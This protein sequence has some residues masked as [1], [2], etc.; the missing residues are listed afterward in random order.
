M[1][2]DLVREETEIEARDRI[3]GKDGW[4]GKCRECAH[5]NEKDLCRILIK[6]VHPEMI[7]CLNFKSK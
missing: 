4:I 5:I 1:F 7:G 2:D 6:I 3:Y